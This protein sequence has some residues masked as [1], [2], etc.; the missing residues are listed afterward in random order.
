MHVLL[1][2]GDDVPLHIA[3]EHHGFELGESGG[4]RLDNLYAR[5]GLERLVETPSGN[6]G[7]HATVIGDDEFFS[8]SQGWPCQRHYCDSTGRSKELTAG[9]ALVEQTVG[10]IE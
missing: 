1:F 3:G 6:L 10:L 4:G 2:G 8:R 5:S 7:G 9:D